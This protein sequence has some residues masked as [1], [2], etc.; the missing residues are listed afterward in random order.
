MKMHGFMVPSHVEG[1]P[2]STA[3]NEGS[4]NVVIQILSK[5]RMDLV[6]LEKEIEH[7]PEEDTDVII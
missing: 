3:F 1:D 2:Y 7:I 5:V 6:A 4:R